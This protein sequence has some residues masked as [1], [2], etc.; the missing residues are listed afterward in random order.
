MAG[1]RG[2][3]KEFIFLIVLLAILIPTAGQAGFSFQIALVHPPQVLWEKSITTPNLFS[4]AHRNSI[5]GVLVWEAFQID[6]EGQLWLSKIKAES[7][8]VLEYYGLEESRNTWVQQ[9]RKIDSLKIRVTANGEFRLEFNQEKIN[10]SQSV[11]DGTL[12]EIRT[13]KIPDK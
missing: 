8:S 4:L 13:R 11:P 5:Y 7:P 1:E 12:L 9:T 10:L 2:P 3:V 6:P